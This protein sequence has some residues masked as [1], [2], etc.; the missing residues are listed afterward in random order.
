[1]S[2]HIS[3]TFSGWSGDRNNSYGFRYI[4]S[5]GAYV[6]IMAYTSYYPFDNRGIPLAF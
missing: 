5:N 4:H 1:M 6:W 2:K 3:A